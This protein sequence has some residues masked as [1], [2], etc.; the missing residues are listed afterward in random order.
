MERNQNHSSHTAKRM[1]TVRQKKN[2][3]RDR[4]LNWLTAYD[5]LAQMCASS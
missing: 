1:N 3:Q 2:V 4:L 5:T